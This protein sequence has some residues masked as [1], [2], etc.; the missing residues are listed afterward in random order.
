[1]VDPYPRQQAQIFGDDAPSYDRF[2][3]AYPREL[4]EEIVERSG[5]TTPVL[6]I[7]AGTG[8]ATKALTALDRRVH[9]LEPDRRMAA[10][11]EVNCAGSPVTVE[12]ATL[13]SA[14]LAPE[15]FHL[16][17][18]AQSW[19]WVDPLVGYDLVADALVP[20]GTLALLWHHPR[21]D[22]GM[23]GAALERLYAELAPSIDA[24]LPGDKARRFDPELEPE[25]AGERFDEWLRL[26][27]RWRR[28]LDA[29][30]LIGWLCS[31]SDHR[32]LPVAER[33]ALMSGVAAL[34]GEFGGT[35]TIAMSTVA[36]LGRRI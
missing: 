22:Q 33:S 27:H 26:E 29:P 6:E 21:E 4:L 10:V 12:H 16:A 23:F 18:A 25:P 20:D 3:P 13:E 15:H 2:R 9:A 7:G 34:V 32:L 1:M 8:K 31:S 28:T 5:P 17:V 35:V 14:R 36:H 11:L 30:N 19:H 24:V